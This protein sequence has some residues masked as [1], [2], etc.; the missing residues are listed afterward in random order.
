MKL[1]DELKRQYIDS[2]EMNQLLQ[3]S[4]ISMLSDFLDNWD[5]MKQ[6][7]QQFYADGYP[8]VVLC[9]IN[10]GRLGAGKTGIPFIDFASLSKMIPEVCRND[11]E[12]SASFFFDVVQSIGVKTFYQHFYVTNISWIGF[13]HNNRNVNY[14]QLP[15]AAKDFVYRMFRFEMEQVQAATIISLGAVVHDT[16]R[17]CFDDTDIDVSQALPHPNYCA[18]PKHY[19]RCKAQYIEVLSEYIK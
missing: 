16:V 11:S 3:G 12:R 10:P 9:G 17:G 2:G 7:E 6:F 14:D 15:D 4:D 13:Q 8:K 18:F 5:V 19:E 1:L